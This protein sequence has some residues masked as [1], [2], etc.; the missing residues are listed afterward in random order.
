MGLVRCLAGWQ[1]S[2]ELGNRRQSRQAVSVRRVH[3]WMDQQ[4]WGQCGRE[5]PGIGSQQLHAASSPGERE[6]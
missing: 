1:H 2:A 3:M 6:S 4:Q 5:K